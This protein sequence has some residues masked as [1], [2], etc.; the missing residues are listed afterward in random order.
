MEGLDGIAKRVA[1]MQGLRT[2]PP[3]S[4]GGRRVTR[5]GD[6][7]KQTF[8]TLSDGSE[9][10]TGQPASDVLYYVLEG[11]DKIIVRPS[12]TEPKVKIYVLAHADSSEALAA[13]IALYEKDA[14][15][16]AD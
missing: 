11:G 4:F 12:G 14:K 5:I 10:P 8:T 15:A 2:T 9:E 16:L 6:Y 13:Q 3:V 7:K 1:L